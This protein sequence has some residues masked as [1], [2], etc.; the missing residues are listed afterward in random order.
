[1]RA[2]ALAMCATAYLSHLTV[3]FAFVAQRWLV[4][5]RC[6]LRFELRCELMCSL[7]MLAIPYVSVVGAV[8]VAAVALP[9]FAQSAELV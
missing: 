5:S 1:M 7:H 3:A 9:L 6:E 8:R 2:T 4:C